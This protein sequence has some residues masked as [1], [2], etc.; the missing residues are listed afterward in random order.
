M[1]TIVEEALT[2]M[3]EDLI[4]ES[5]HTV[6]RNGRLITPER[7][8]ELQGRLADDVNLVKSTFDS[9]ANDRQMLA[10][11]GTFV[12][13]NQSQRRAPDRQMFWENMFDMLD[14]LF[15]IDHDG[16]LHRMIWG[17]KTNLL[18][19][20]SGVSEEV[21]RGIIKHQLK[22]ILISL[23]DKLSESILNHQMHRSTNFRDMW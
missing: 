11:H 21:S 6:M 9:I 15:Q 8:A 18:T 7:R 5:L 10:H 12:M 14:K 3:Y 13:I 1:D 16:D 22:P 20:R 23:V 4:E 17:M 2:E 19:K